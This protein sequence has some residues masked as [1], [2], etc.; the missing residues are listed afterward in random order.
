[1]D[2][3]GPVPYAPDSDPD[4]DRDLVPTDDRKRDPSPRERDPSIS[5]SQNP[6]GLV[7]PLAQHIH[8]QAR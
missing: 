3:A 6:Q 8:F 7:W 5:Y 1:M 2:G 4:R